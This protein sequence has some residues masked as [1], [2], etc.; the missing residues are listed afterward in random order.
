MHERERHRLIVRAVQEKPVVTVAEFVELT[1]ASEAT[2]RRDINALDGEDKLRRVYGGAEALHPPAFVGIA[3]RTFQVNQ[4]VNIERKR[5]IADRAAALCADGESIIID[6]GTTTFQMVHRLTSHRLQIL[7]N[8]FPVAEYM[9]HHSKSTVIL[10]GGVIYREQEIILSP[11]SSDMQRSFCAQR[12]FFGAQGLGPLGVMGPDALVIQGQ[13][14]LIDQAEELVL[15]VD[16]SKFRLRSSLIICPLD[17]VDII[18]TDDGIDTAARNLIERTGIQLIVAQTSER[19]DEA[20]RFRAQA[21]PP[22]T[23]DERK[24]SAA[25][26]R[27]ADG[28]ELLDHG[29]TAGDEAAGQGRNRRPRAANEPEPARGRPRTRR[30]LSTGGSGGA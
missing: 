9:L 10:T 11:F 29:E 22:G 7:T 20:A 13:R 15:L 8:S 24:R 21:G 16:S 6:G 4:P 1:G 3:G 12:M 27:T 5:A 14:A 19:S 18:I 23:D 28:A 2:V 26:D 25:G 30:R 17:R